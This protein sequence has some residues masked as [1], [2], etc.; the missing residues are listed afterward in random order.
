M[1]RAP[2]ELFQ[3]QRGYVRAENAYATHEIE[4]IEPDL[5]KVTSCTKSNAKM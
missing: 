2:D 5:L 1:T 4:E 3:P